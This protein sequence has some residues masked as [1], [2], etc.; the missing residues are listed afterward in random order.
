V[1]QGLRANS[2]LRRQ[3]GEDGVSLLEHCI[4]ATERILPHVQLGAWVEGG[5][6]QPEA[7]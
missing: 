4:G 3:I 5:W 1:A 2:V 6:T 7:F